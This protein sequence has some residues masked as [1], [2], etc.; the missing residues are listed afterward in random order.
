MVKEIQS[1][2]RLR[3]S[4]DRHEVRQQY[5]PMFWNTLAKRLEVE[6]KEALD[7]IIGLMDDYFLTKE[8]WDAIVELGVGPFNGEELLKRIPSTTKATFTRQYVILYCCNIHRH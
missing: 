7:D 8:D 5:I 4:A 2:M 6:G 1:H 3:S